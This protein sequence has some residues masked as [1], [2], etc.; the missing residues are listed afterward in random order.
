ML[1]KL[2]KISKANFFKI[3]KKHRSIKIFKKIEKS[4]PDIAGNVLR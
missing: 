2:S 3:E 4:R 1:M